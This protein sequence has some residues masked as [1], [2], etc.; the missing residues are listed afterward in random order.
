MSVITISRG[1]FSQGKLV[2]EKL[3]EKLGYSCVSREILLSA[4]KCLNIPETKLANALNE[5]PSFFDRFSKEKECFIRTIRAALL[6]YIKKDNVVYHGVFG[7]YFLKDIDHILKIRIQANLENRVATLMKQEK[8]SEI[9]AITHLK[10]ID[11]DRKKWGRYL[12]GFEPQHPNLYDLVIHVDSLT[13]DDIVDVICH[14]VSLSSFQATDESRKKLNDL[15]LSAEVHALL[16]EI[17]VV[18]VTSKNGN[19][20]INLEAPLNQKDR[21]NNEIRDLTRKTEG[22]N[23]IELIFK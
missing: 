16:L 15:A 22:I 18:K 5:A 20:Q 21:L 12:Y 17:P 23:D 13:I 3:A 7:Q 14:T 1:S 19:V 10:K 11:D 9:Q 6:N 2:A 8:M 4:A